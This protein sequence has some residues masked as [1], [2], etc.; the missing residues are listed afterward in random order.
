MNGNRVQGNQPGVDSTDHDPIQRNK[1][2]LRCSPKLLDG[3]SMFLSLLLGFLPGGTSF[4][5]LNRLGFWEEYSLGNLEIPFQ[6]DLNSSV[7]RNGI[8]LRAMD[9]ERTG[10]VLSYCTPRVENKKF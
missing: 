5:F 7:I 3:I 10:E 4:G 1:D 2:C 6:F 8:K 9:D